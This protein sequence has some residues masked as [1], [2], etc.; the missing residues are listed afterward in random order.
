MGRN[1][2][3]PKPV[4]RIDRNWWNATR[5]RGRAALFLCGGGFATL[6][7][8]KWPYQHV[9]RKISDH[10]YRKTDI[11]VTCRLRQFCCRHWAINLSHKGVVYHMFDTNWMPI[12][13]RLHPTGYLC[14]GGDGNV[15]TSSK[16]GVRL[17]EDGSSRRF[18]YCR[19]GVSNVT[20]VLGI[21]LGSVG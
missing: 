1:V 20:W 15:C 7:F 12:W 8:W 18:P 10:G 3:R 21:E 17:E 6:N 5:A 14:G 2:K 9:S 19:W 16:I 13:L 11:I 4:V